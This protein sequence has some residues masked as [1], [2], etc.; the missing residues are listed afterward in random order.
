MSETKTT[1]VNETFD[2][3]T[4]INALPENVRAAISDG[5]LTA[6]KDDVTYT[7]KDGDGKVT[8]KFLKYFL[9]LVPSG[10]IGDTEVSA[11]A[12]LAT[13]REFLVTDDKDA[14]EYMLA[15]QDGTVRLAI[16]S[17]IVNSIEGPGKAIEKAIKAVEFLK[18]VNPEAY[19]NAVK[20]IKAA[21]AVAETAA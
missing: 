20:A 4:E 7:Q 15:G 12:Q 18:A 8:G 10:K 1:I 14:L 5:R 13:A 6:K 9:K 16:R 3:A 11:S 19:E 21:N 17:S 2:L